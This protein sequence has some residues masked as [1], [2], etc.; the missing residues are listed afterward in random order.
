MTCVIREAEK[1]QDSSWEGLISCLQPT[2][3]LSHGVLAIWP[4]NQP[5]LHKALRHIQR[6][7]GIRPV[8]PH[9]RHGG[10]AAAASAGEVCVQ[11]RGQQKLQP[12]VYQRT[13]PR[14]CLYPSLLK[15]LNFTVC[16][17]M[18]YCT[19]IHSGS[20]LSAYKWDT[21]LHWLKT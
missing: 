20:K 2:M 10:A 17:Q 9:Q 16:F 6:W 8:L 11:G 21:V 13:V 14:P 12:A 7:G 4:K 3:I 15:S 1:M 18:K 19:L 5:F